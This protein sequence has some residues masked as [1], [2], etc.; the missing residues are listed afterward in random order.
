MKHKEVKPKKKLIGKKR[1]KTSK[2]AKKQRTAMVTQTR[3]NKRKKSTNSLS[4]VIAKHKKYCRRCV[5]ATNR[6]KNSSKRK[7]WPAKNSATSQNS[8]KNSKMYVHHHSVLHLWK[9]F[10]KGRTGRIRTLARRHPNRRKNLRT[11]RIPPQRDLGGAAESDSE[12]WNSVANKRDPAT[13]GS[14]EEESDQV[15]AGPEREDNFE[16]EQDRLRGRV[17]LAYSSWKLPLM[18][19]V[20]YP[21]LQE[22]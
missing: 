7:N 16:V 21:L 1:E 9:V 2:P 14:A 6:T 20:V 13:G 10:G 3:P 22:T 4:W 11:Q 18:T 17:I 15:A 5:S 12:S 19:C 8:P